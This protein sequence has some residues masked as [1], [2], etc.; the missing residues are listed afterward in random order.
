MPLVTASNRYMQCVD[1]RRDYPNLWEA[2]QGLDQ[3]SE[4]PAFGWPIP[5]AERK[6]ASWNSIRKR[7]PQSHLLHS[8][9][10]QQT[11]SKPSFLS[12]LDVK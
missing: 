11:N 5:S 8:P 7:R 9:E 2:G 12:A 6:T 4:N 1:G 3:H 10:Y